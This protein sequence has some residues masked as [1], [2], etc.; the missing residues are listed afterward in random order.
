[1][2]DTPTDIEQRISKMM[3]S[4]SPQERLLMVNNMFH[5]GKAL[6]LAS[7]SAQ[8]R[9][10]TPQQTRAQLFRR[11][12]AADFTEEELATICAQFPRSP[13]QP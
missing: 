6:V 2:R 13:L 1:M 5:T 9:E 7:I 11:M 8:R 10:L 12:Y 3:Q 4:R